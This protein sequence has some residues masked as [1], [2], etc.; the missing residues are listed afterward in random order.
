MGHAAS[1][2][3][4]SL[5]ISPGVQ[6]TQ[7]LLGLVLGT[8]LQVVY[9]LFSG[10]LGEPSPASLQG[11]YCPSGQLHLL[12][13]SGPACLPVSA[14][15]CPFPGFFLLPA[16]GFL[17]WFSGT[18]CLP[19]PQ[20]ALPSAC[21]FPHLPLPGMLL[22]IPKIPAGPPPSSGV[23]PAFI[24]NSLPAPWTLPVVIHIMLTLPFLF[25]K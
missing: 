6:S 11:C 17:A 1:I 25:G 14:L 5:S 18:I 9:L 24:P 10:D 4:C 2:L 23:L 22:L 12:Q 15:S 16:S 3:S 7:H 21:K 13:D 20:V 19:A 8:P